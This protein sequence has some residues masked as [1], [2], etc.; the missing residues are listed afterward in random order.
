M[1]NLHRT[2]GID[3]KSGSRLAY[4]LSNSWIAIGMC[5]LWLD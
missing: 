3:V 2:Q 5:G 4:E 1:D